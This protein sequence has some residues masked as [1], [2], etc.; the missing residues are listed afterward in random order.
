[1]WKH[2]RTRQA[3]QRPLPLGKPHGKPHEE[4]GL[5][6]KGCHSDRCAFLSYCL[7]GLATGE[8]ACRFLRSQA[9]R[10]FVGF[11]LAL[12]EA[13]RGKALSDP[14]PA[15]RAVEALVRVRACRPG[16]PH[17]RPSS[18]RICAF[19]RLHARP[20]CMPHRRPA[21]GGLVRLHA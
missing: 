16:R 18:L 3:L 1:M 20:G 4:A 13:V 17:L 21:V 7:A 9:A 14:C 10:D 11:L 6:S 5:T 19:P 8:A 15:S 12:N 2:E